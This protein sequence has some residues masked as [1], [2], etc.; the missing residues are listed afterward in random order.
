MNE[1]AVK[2]PP[3]QP[4]TVRTAAGA[5]NEPPT[6]C[7]ETNELCT[8]KCKLPNNTGRTYCVKWAAKVR[9]E[10]AEEKRRRASPQPGRD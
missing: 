2:L 8:E 5:M 10:G 6:I 4:P 1:T 7:P 3:A 9:A